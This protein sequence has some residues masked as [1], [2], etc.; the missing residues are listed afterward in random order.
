MYSVRRWIAAINIWIIFMIPPAVA[1]TWFALFLP[2]SC[3]GVCEESSRRPPQRQG[4]WRSVWCR[5]GGYTGTGWRSCK[6]TYTHA[7][8]MYAWPFLLLRRSVH[9]WWNVQVEKAIKK[10]KEQLLKERYH[11]NMGL[12][13][14]IILHWANIFLISNVSVNR[15]GSPHCCLL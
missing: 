2:C 9:Q 6:S 4:V 15:N 8:T 13:M 10:H 11:F 5:C 7:V 1:T 12:L 14:G 3:S